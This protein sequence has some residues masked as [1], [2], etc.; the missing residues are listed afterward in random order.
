MALSV[1]CSPGKRGDLNLSLG[2]CVKKLGWGGRG[3]QIPRDQRSATQAL[4]N[5]K[6][7]TLSLKLKVDNAKRMRP[8]VDP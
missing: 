7:E 2:T 3:R 5:F 6:L 1:K 8:K 4:V